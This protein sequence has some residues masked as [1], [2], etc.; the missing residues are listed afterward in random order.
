MPAPKNSFKAALGGDAPQLGTWLGF[1]DA[2]IAEAACTADFD[3]FLIDGE[4][5][6]NDIPSILAQAQVVQGAGRQAVV[7]LP[8]GETWMIKQVL[9]L[10][11]QTLLM[12]MVDS[13]AQAETLVRDV[14]Y[15]PQGH[16]GVGSALAR[17]SMFSATPDYLASANDEICLLVQ[18]ENRAGMAALDDI[19]TVEGVDG[20]FIGPSDLA[21]D[22]GYLGDPGAPAVQAAIAEAVSKIKAAGKAAGIMA[23][24]EAG[25]RKWAEAGCDFIAV[26]IDVVLYASQMRAL[27]ASRKA[28]LTG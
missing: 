13:A 4:H 26:C 12:P 17:A 25:G 9:D 14:R 15:P 5:A 3:W 22:M 19:L 2:Y 21:A 24:D 1:A 28:A 18:V 7:R 27:A 20:V 8:I 23:L 6:P 11:V 16:R 10:G